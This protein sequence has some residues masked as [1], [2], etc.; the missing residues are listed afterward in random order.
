MS[1]CSGI[2]LPRGTRGLPCRSSIWAGSGP[3]DSVH[4]GGKGTCSLEELIVPAAELNVKIYACDMSRELLESDGRAHKLP[5]PWCLRRRHIRRA[6]GRRKSIAVSASRAAMAEVYE[7]TVEERYLSLCEILLR[8]TKPHYRH[9]CMLTVVCRNNGIEQPP[10][11]LAHL[12][13]LVEALSTAST[14]C[15]AH[16]V[17]PV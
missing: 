5:A 10:Q 15:P 6:R 16:D 3:G 12:E 13:Q 1:G 4:H 2:M 9:Q 14:F 8:Y 11:S 17:L 7:P